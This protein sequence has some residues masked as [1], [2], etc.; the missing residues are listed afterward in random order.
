MPSSGPWYGQAR[1]WVNTLKKTVS[2]LCKEACLDVHY[3]LRATA[4]VHMYEG[5]VPENIISEK[6]LGTEALRVFMRMRGLQYCRRR[7]QGH[8]LMLESCFVL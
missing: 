3:T 5:G 7:L 1:L 8:L 4:I 2:E 6:S